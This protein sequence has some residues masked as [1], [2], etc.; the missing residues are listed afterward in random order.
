VS[1]GRNRLEGTKDEAEGAVLFLRL[2]TTAQS[3]DDM[4][5]VFKR[6]EMLLY[7]TLQPAID[8]PS[9]Y[10]GRNDLQL[11]QLFFSL[12]PRRRRLALHVRTE[13]EGVPV[14]DDEV[15]KLADSER[16]DFVGGERRMGG[17]GGE[18]AKSFEGS[19]AL[20]GVPV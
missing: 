18:A 1:K 8:Y 3:I 6:R 14:D 10:H 13:Y 20:F 5:L 15:G 11:P 17:G 12:P 2:L 7:N 9:F 19:E 16:A 4:S